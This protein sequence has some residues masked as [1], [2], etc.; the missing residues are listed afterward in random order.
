MMKRVSFLL[1]SLCFMVQMHAQ[2]SISGIVTGNDSEALTGANVV[3]HETFRGTTTDMNGI[4]RFSNLKPGNYTLVVSY[5]GYESSE[6]KIQLAKDEFLE[7]QLHEAALMGDE[8][9]IKGT[10]VGNKTPSSYSNIDKDE[11]EKTNFGQDLPVLLNRMT[12]V[13]STTDAGNGVGYTGMRIR[14]TDINRINVTINGIPFNDPE[15]HS[16]YWVD[17][18]DITSSIDNIQIQRGVGTSSN[19]AAAFGA[20]IDLQT[21]KLNHEPFANAELNYGSFNS[22]KSNLSFGTGLLKNRFTLDG[23]LSKISSDGFIDRAWSDLKSFYV[24]GGYY[25]GKTIMRL[26]AFSGVEETYQAWNGVPK[27]RLNNDLEGMQRYEEHWLYTPEETRHMISSDSRT[28]NMYTYENEIDHYQQNHYQL[29][30]SQKVSNCILINSALFYVRGAGYYEQYKDEEDLA[31]YH[32]AYPVIGNEEITTSDIIRRKWLDNDFYGFISNLIYKRDRIDVTFGGGLNLYDGNH[33]GKVIWT[34]YA[35]NSS[36][37]HEW[38]RNKGLKSDLNVYGK[39]NYTLS[40]HFNLYGDL[41]YRGIRYDIDGID[42]NNDSVSMHD[43]NF[44]FVNPK[45]GVFYTISDY[46]T[47]FV[48]FSVANREPNR[49]NYLDAPTGE[50]P[51]SETLY[52]FEIGY[53][54][55]LTNLQIT[56]NLYNM[57]YRNQLVLTGEINDVGDAIMV[58]VPHSY[59]RGIEVSGTCKISKF[60]NWYGNVTF[61]TNKIKDFTEYVDN[62]NYW[63]DIENQP[64]QYSNPLGKTDISFSPGLVTANIF[65]FMPIQGLSIS[66]LSKYVSKQYIDNTSSDERSL[67]PYFVNDLYVNYKIHP[68]FIGEINLKLMINNILNEAYETNAWVYRYY[69]NNMHYTMDG[70]FPQAGTN[71]MAGISVKF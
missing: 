71:L 59:R 12:S 70:Y 31:D 25:S 69:Y 34:Q 44:D 21:T 33:F 51:G 4:F 38:Y 1:A 7:I 5:I 49:S 50:I 19:G 32:I 66:L 10:R 28:Y 53:S 46:N 55:K 8:V 47:T 27:V 22:F 24:S 2:F 42:D 68:A 3:L 65:N 56:T 36:I 15:S 23:R 16:V 45:I 54:L 18:P 39:L 35:G 14:G 37:N 9:I 43:L 60:L 61:S 58:N 30:F 64:L 20:T 62:W 48:S 52:N 29:H 63:D 17:L 26:Y 67:S 40:K 13:V 41:Q 6:R 57:S 11:L